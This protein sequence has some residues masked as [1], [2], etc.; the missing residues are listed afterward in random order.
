[1]PFLSYAP[2]GM[3]WS[4]AIASAAGADHV[5]PR[6]KDWLTITS[7]LVFATYGS[8]GA[9]VALLRMSDQTTARCF[10]LVGSAAML[11]PAERDRIVGK[12]V[13]GG[14]HLDRS[15]LGRA[16]CGVDLDDLVVVA[17]RVQVGRVQERHEDAPV[18]RYDG[19]GHEGLIEVARDGVEGR[20]GVAAVVSDRAV[21]DGRHEASLLALTEIAVNDDRVAS[22]PS[23]DVL[24]VE[25]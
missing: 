11:L 15:T 25:H 22:T 2:H 21:N 12:T 24:L 10:A 1:M 18:R 17:A 8:L 16:G 23:G 4:P 19:R 6:S 7:E 13:N 20:P 9:G 14:R 5:L 3:N